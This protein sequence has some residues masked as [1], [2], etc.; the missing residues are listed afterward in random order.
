MTPATMPNAPA[1][2][3]TAPFDTAQRAWLNGMLAALYPPLHPANPNRKPSSALPLTIL[4]GT[5]T[6]TTGSLAKKVAKAAQTYNLAPTVTDFASYEPANL[7]KE[8]HV[9]ILTSTY[10]DGEPPDSVKTFYDHLHSAS[11]PSLENIA[12]SVLGLGDSGYPEF[13]Q[14]ARDIDSRLA[15]LGATRIADPVFCDVD[16]DA[17]AANW[18][19]ACFTSLSA[20]ASS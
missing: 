3:E 19:T 2:P 10:G 5:Q 18:Q 8:T 7:A 6:G 14:C 15:A 11:A 16:Y 9:L 12:Y 4:F 17:D 13:N 20:I 1:L